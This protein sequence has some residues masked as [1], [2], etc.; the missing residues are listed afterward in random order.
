MPLRQF[1]Y[2]HK[3]QRNS[4]RTTWWSRKRVVV[5][6]YPRAV[7][8]LNSSSVLEMPWT[9]TPIIAGLISAIII[10]IDSSHR[11]RIIIKHSIKARQ[12]SITNPAII[13]LSSM[14]RNPSKAQ[15]IR[16]FTTI[17]TPPAWIMVTRELAES[18]ACPQVEAA[19]Q[20]PPKVA[21][22]RWTSRWTTAILIRSSLPLPSV[23]ARSVAAPTRFLLL[24][25]CQSWASR[26]AAV[27]ITKFHWPSTIVVACSQS[28]FRVTVLEGGPLIWDSA[29]S[30]LSTP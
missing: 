23:V 21:S 29:T 17:T 22:T 14:T 9:T 24:Q 3:Q 19:P 2:S 27:C 13:S 6:C 18:R 12:A 15:A 4:T 26:S 11:V 30:Q 8:K 5:D 28:S 1:P 10:I 7:T 20:P 25:T 16:W